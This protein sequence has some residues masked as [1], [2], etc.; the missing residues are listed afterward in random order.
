RRAAAGVPRV[1]Q[2]V[3]SLVDTHV[4]LW[5]LKQQAVRW[6]WL[7]W[8]WNEPHPLFGNYD[9]IK[10]PR[11]DAAAL[12]AAPRGAGTAKIGTVQA[13]VGPPDPVAETEWLERQAAATG[14]PSAIVAHTDLKSPHVERELDRH[15]EA[16]PRLRGIRD[17]SEGDYLVDP[18]FCRGYAAL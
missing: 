17:F 14:W 5:D 7:E 6:Q 8:N 3:R 16:S 2:A 12:R 13:A 9:P 15:A 18:A 4:H 10:A 1:T 11:F